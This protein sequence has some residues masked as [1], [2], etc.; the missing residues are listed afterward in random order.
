MSPVRLLYFACERANCLYASTEFP[1]LKE[2][3]QGAFI[4]A[5]HKAEPWVDAAA[6]FLAVRCHHDVHVHAKTRICMLKTLVFS[7]RLHHGTHA[8][9]CQVL[10]SA[11][12]EP[13]QHANE[14]DAVLR[15][16]WCISFVF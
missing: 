7:G 15:E 2:L 6:V 10:H 12:H 1:R 14:V 8:K 16:S 9:H 13:F 5:L 11:W 4:S 3:L